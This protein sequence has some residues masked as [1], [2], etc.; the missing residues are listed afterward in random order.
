MHSLR[1][2]LAARLAGAGPLSNRLA[3]APAIP[4]R[5][6][7]GARRAGTGVGGS[8]AARPPFDR[9][10]PGVAASAKRADI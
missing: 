8:D 10:V 7:R 4:H 5:R 3:L 6:D 1:S 9:A 2:L